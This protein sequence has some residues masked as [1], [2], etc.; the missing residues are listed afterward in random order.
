MKN[1]DP[2]PQSRLAMEEF[3]GLQRSL[4]FEIYIRSPFYLYVPNGE[5][6]GTDE[7][8][9]TYKRTNQYRWAKPFFHCVPKSLFSKILLTLNLL[10]SPYWYYIKEALRC[11]LESC[12]NDHFHGNIYKRLDE[13]F[14]NKKYLLIFCIFKNNII[15]CFIKVCLFS[16]F[17]SFYF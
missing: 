6:S 2:D 10:I 11:N 9:S 4:S 12:R 13:H 8:Q 16:N 5:K 15:F 1:M 7:S 14:R 3:S 17:A